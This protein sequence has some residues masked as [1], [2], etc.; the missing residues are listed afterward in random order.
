MQTTKEEK[1]PE[2]GF[3]WPKAHV[4]TLAQK[5]S[6]SG[7]PSEMMSPSSNTVSAYHK[8]SAQ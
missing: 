4:Q 3:V 2:V 5:T 8:I 1:V 6:R 7:Q